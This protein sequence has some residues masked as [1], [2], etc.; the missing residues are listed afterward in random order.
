MKAFPWIV[1]LCAW[2]IFFFTENKMDAPLTVL[3]DRVVSDVAEQVSEGDMGHK[4]FTVVMGGMGAFLW[5]KYRR[6]VRIN[7]LMTGIFVTYLGWICLGALT[8]DDPSLTVRRLGGFVLVLLLCA[9]CAVRMDVDSNSLFLAGIPALTLI[10]DV[11]AELRCHGFQALTPDG[12]F[13][14]TYAHPNVA[15]AT[16]ALPVIVFGWMALRTRGATRLWFFCADVIV[17]AFLLLTRSRTSIVGVVVALAF[18]LAIIIL[19]DQRQHL[20]R[21]LGIVVLAVGVTGLAGL[22]LNSSHDGLNLLSALHSE[23]DEGDPTT[24]TGRTDLW[25]TCLDY[26]YERPILGF[27]FSGFWSPKHIEEISEEQKWPINQSHSAYLDQALAL[28]FPGAAL[29]VIVMFGC[30]IV[31]TARY[32]RSE[33]EFGVWAALLVF[34]AV[35]SI[36][37]AISLA[38]GYVNFVLSLMAVQI[39]LIRQGASID[40]AGIGPD[41]SM[42]LRGP[43]KAA[44]YQYASQARLYPDTSRAQKWSM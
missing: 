32:F 8:A 6:R 9:G 37:E 16:L 44:T 26:V 43:V 42:N 17:S 33:D 24:L 35:N 2:C 14:G 19:R 11:I 21:L 31:C 10:P 41:K 20:V 29:Y 7:R 5:F 15:G 39:A 23:R 40:Q 18:S 25:K 22:A 38:P 4:V 13:G 27:G 30:L 12:R 28:G 3:E 36:T 34:I 1:F